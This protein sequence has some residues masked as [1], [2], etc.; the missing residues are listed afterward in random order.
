MVLKSPSSTVL[1]YRCL[2][3]L[4]ALQFTFQR[5]FKLL[6]LHGCWRH[7]VPP[8]PLRRIRPGTA[9][10]WS[11]VTRPTV[12]PVPQNMWNSMGAY[13]M[14]TYQGLQRAGVTYG[15][16]HQILFLHSSYIIIV[17]FVLTVALLAFIIFLSFSLFPISSYPPS[18]R[19]PDG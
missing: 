4:Q 12:T 18:P 14:A 6:F 9:Q 16:H 11:P 17:Y 13:S 10:R 5:L 8:E 1:Y 19:P 7:G 15:K 2:T 3:S